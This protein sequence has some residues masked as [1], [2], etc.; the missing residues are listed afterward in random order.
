M[1]KIISIIGNVGVGKTTA[2]KALAAALGFQFFAESHDDRP[3]QH[4]A[5]IEPRFIFHN[6]VN[7]FLERV[8]QEELARASSV[9]GV[10]DGGLDIDFHIFTKLF[11]YKNIITQLEY[12]Q[13]SD[14]Y[15][16]F[17]RHLPYPDT[18]IYLTANQEQI[19][20][21]YLARTR[22][23]LAVLADIPL[24]QQLLEDYINTIPTYNILYYDTNEEEITYHTFIA[25]VG[26]KL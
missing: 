24:I 1:A 26:T 21:R 2:A 12:N 5:K 23:N 9:P 16:F 25:T 18:I 22:I 7:Y 4:I 15:Q 3:F 13:L 17:R 8:K 10:F 11:L 6:Q 19:K 14:L 20:Q